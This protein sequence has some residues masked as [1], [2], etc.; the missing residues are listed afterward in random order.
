MLLR[1]FA[2]PA[3][4]AAT[5]GVAAYWADR[6][7]NP[8]R[9][10]HS[11]TTH[12]HC[13]VPCGIYDDPRRIADLKEDIKTILKA[14]RQVNEICKNTG[15]FPEAQ[16][17]NQ[18]V[19]WV[20]TKEEHASHVIDTVSQYFLTQKVKPKNKGDEGY[21]EY[22][23]VL[24]AHHRVMSAAMKAKQSADPET[25]HALEHAVDDLGK[26]YSA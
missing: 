13:Q 12:M 6:D 9:L 8:L 15:P 7:E 14:Q 21:D 1:R 22:L 3:A 10:W 17:M 16:A 11:T 4:A 24:A 2:L 5:T 20:N 26:I 23:E 19:R 18:A 25:A